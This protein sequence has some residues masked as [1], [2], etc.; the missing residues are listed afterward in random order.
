MVANSNIGIEPLASLVA[1][2]V[3]VGLW[4]GKA[5]ANILEPFQKGLD[6]FPEKVT[7][8]SSAKSRS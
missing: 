4:S 8:R 3:A 2:T 6:S 5:V 1:V 7:S